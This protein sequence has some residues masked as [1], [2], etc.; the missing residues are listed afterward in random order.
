ML[1]I[2]E[3][4]SPRGRGNWLNR[5]DFTEIMHEIIITNIYNGLLSG[6]VVETSDL[7]YQKRDLRYNH[8]NIFAI[9][10]YKRRLFGY[11]YSKG[12]DFSW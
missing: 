8:F 10:H 4:K 12:N 5:D 3:A 1:R 7:C 9:V 6:I 11:K 2:A